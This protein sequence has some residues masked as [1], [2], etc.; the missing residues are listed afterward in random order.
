MI[1]PLH[2]ILLVF[3]TAVPFTSFAEST[4]D[5]HIRTLSASCFACH[6][7]EGNPTKSNIAEKQ[8]TIA[9]QAANQLAK[10]LI[11]FKNQEVESTVMH[12]H[13]KGLTLDEINLL[14]NYFSKQPSTLNNVLPPNQSL[15][16]QHE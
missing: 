9:G 3:S 15:E 16:S 5:L 14:A 6:G 11:A 13:A 8:K 7:Y 12:H 2:V 10:K 1:K 4:S